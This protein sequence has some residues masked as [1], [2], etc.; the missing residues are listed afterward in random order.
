MTDTGLTDLQRIIDGARF[1]VPG[2]GLKLT[3]PAEASALM[4]HSLP[5]YIVGTSGSPRNVV[6]H[7]VFVRSAVMALEEDGAE[8]W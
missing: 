4:Q 7:T 1:I 2:E 3:L 6:F 5:P 8:V